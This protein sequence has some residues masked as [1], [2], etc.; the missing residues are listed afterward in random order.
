MP[1]LSKMIHDLASRN[2]E[3][4]KSIRR[5]LHQHPELSKEER[6]T[7]DYICHRLDQ[8]NI[9]YQRGV[10]GNGVVG[11]I[12]GKNPGKRCIALRADMDALPMKEENKADYVSQEP[13]KMHAC[14]H[15]VHMA[16]LLGAARI[17]SELKEQFEGTVKLLFQ[18]SE[19]TFPGGA[20]GM[21]D[22]GVL[23][24]PD[25]QMVIG[26][27]VLPTLDTGK[28]GFNPGPD[29]ASTDEIFLTIKGKGGHAAI[30]NI[31]ID[32]VVIAAHI[33][34]ALQ[35]IVSRQAEPTLPTVISFGRIVGEG[36]TN[37]IP[38]E[39]KI[40]G[41]VRTYDE[42]WRKEIHRKI[43][44]IAS[45]IAVSMGGSCEVK[46]SSGYPYLHNEEQLTARLQHLAGEYLG[47]GNVVKLERR[48]TAEDFAYFAQRL[49]SCLYRL[50]IRNEARGI[51]SGLHSSTFDIDETA[52]E[53]GAGLLVWFAL[54]LLNKK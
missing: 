40:D 11:L 28:A 15:D 54:N 51:D 31:V 4:I 30:P 20:I 24:N 52:L 37:I 22:E 49:P 7:A 53:T 35:Q 25:V 44:T 34:L 43:E 47:E 17:L 39:V 10:A 32:P 33:I 2:F 45:S 9:P 3:E 18:P 12:E 29:M 42:T 23:D 36:R 8:Y 41:T 13:G 6:R 1:E 46:I 14:G 48:M 50:G 21:I 38:N 5:H 16:C 19:E 27:H 26:Q